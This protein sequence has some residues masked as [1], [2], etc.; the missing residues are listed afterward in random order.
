MSNLGLMF[1]LGMTGQGA[2]DRGMSQMNRNGSRNAR[3]LAGAWRSA[4]REI[5]AIGHSLRNVAVMAGGAGAIK[6]VVADVAEF[7]RGL[8]EMRITGEL[9]A[10]ELAILRKQILGMARPDLQL[11]EDQLAGFQKMVAAGIDPRQAI[12][13][14]HDINRAAT[15]SFSDVRDMAGTSIDLMQKMDIVPE[16][17]GRSFD[18]LAKGGKLGKFELK[19][20]AQYIPEV[21]SDM[22]RFGIV[23]ER[24][25]AQMTAML[26]IA[27]RGTAIPSQAATNMQNFFGHITQYRG[28]FKKLGINIWEFIDPKDDKIRAG[29]DVDD[30][31]REIIRKTGGSVA[32]LEMAGIRDVQAKAFI[33]RMMQDFKDYERIRDSALNAKGTI[34]QDFDTAKN[35]T[36]GKLKESQ[37]AKSE[38][39]KSRG[40]SIAAGAGAD[41]LGWA[42]DNPLKTA[43]L[44]YGG[45]R[46]YKA[47]RNRMGGSGGLP[48][49]A[50]GMGG[51]GAPIPVYVVNK[52]LSML[53][54]EWGGKATLPGEAAGSAA[55]TAVKRMAAYGALAVRNPASVTG[56]ALGGYAIGTWIERRFIKGAIGEALYDLLHPE[57]R[58]E[59]KTDIKLNLNIDANGRASSTTGMNTT[60]TVLPRGSF[61]APMKSH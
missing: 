54:G 44:L 18:I 12:K 43:G 8:T 4:G 14:L 25:I 45:Y 48:G 16:K 56:A 57:E 37:I 58:Q 38:A 35:T 21:A 51:G 13:G 36:W 49:A 34:N 23:G 15:A 59:K 47:I 52:H 46:G 61:F 11:P 19:D 50:G 1:M 32:R 2:V 26:Q 31:F 53:P 33:Q 17:L 42:I 20:M 9:T 27:R 29:K 39:M 3:E 30:F 40:S 22:Q 55:K 6:A 24:G 7:E 41:L 60:V 28:H 5:T 10:R